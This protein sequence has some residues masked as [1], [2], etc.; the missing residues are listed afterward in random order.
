MSIVTVTRFHA[1][2]GLEDQLF[3]LQTEGRRRMLE[4]DGCESFDILRE[5]S[6]PRAFV[7][8]PRWASRE[9]HDAAFGQLIMARGHLDRVL[10][11]LD[12]PVVQNIYVP[13][14]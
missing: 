1:T 13:A 12:E 4:A 3:E 7:F 14:S 11:T 9:S 5:E 10:A 2:D 8:V 6:D